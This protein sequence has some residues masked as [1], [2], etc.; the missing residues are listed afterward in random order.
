MESLGN[1]TPTQLP[2]CGSDIYM[3]AMAGKYLD[4]P[5]VAITP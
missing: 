1:R 2:V 5:L 3:C 4:A